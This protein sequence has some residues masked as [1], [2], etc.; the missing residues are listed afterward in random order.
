MRLFP[1]IATALNRRGIPF[2]W[3]LHG[4]GPD[5]E[6]LKQ[7]FAAEIKKGQ[8]IFSRPVKYKELPSLIRGHDVYLLASTNEGGPLTLLESMAL[9]LV[10]VCGDIPC[11][12]REVITPKNGFRVRRDNPDAYAQAISELNENR[13]LLEN[14]SVAART[15][16]TEQFS[17][18]AMARRYIHFLESLPPQKNAEWP[19]KI[20]P[21]PIL[22]LRSKHL[23]KIA[24]SF[25]ILRQAR[26]YVRK[27]KSATSSW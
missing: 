7:A 22:G 18:E 5:E 15:T 16:I 9:G 26:R 25:G 27:I 19:A 21:R 24:Q 11:L 4:S 14:H 6:F 17:S 1:E 12:V 2:V 13:P 23:R 20:R 3:T 10:P 8:V